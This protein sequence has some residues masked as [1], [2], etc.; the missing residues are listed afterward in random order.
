MRTALSLAPLALFAPVALFASAALAAETV[1]PIFVPDTENKLAPQLQGSTWVDEGETWAIF[2]R[3]LGD[4][5]RL[6][7]IRSKTGLSV[8]PFLSRPNEPAAFMTFLL[9]IE[10]RGEAALAF[11]PQAFWLAANR[12]QQ[13][14][15]QAL[16]DVRF[17]YRV[18]GLEF[19]RAYERIGPALLESPRT[20]PAEDRVSGL[21]VYKALHEKTKRYAIDVKLSLPNGEVARLH[22]PYTRLTKKELEALQ[23]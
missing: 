9:V 5:E 16:T 11:N 6:S 22:A 13:Q 7:Y 23:P 21:L 4:E 14:F 19:P 12:S 17:S 2:L 15:P 1:E 10:N 8:D 20:V 18:A 3:P